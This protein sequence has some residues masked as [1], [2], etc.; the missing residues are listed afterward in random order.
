MLTRRLAIFM[1]RRFAFRF[2]FMNNFLFTYTYNTYYIRK[3]ENIV[4]C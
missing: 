1:K 2:K 4:F 3:Y